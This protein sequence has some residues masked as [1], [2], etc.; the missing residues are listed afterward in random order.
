VAA[1]I[2]A[3]CEQMVEELAHAQIIVGYDVLRKDTKLAKD[4][5]DV[6]EK[7]FQKLPELRFWRYQAQG[8]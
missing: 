3:S 7:Y 1:P 6:I 4:R 8:K 2:S 5:W